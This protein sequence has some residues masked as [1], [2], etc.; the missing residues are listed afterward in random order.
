MPARADTTASERSLSLRLARGFY[1][2]LRVA[3]MVVV[4]GLSR[5]VLRFRRREC[6]GFDPPD[7]VAFDR[8]VTGPERV[9]P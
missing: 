4:R 7:G 1:P 9:V 2:A 6:G 3:Y 8:H 5:F